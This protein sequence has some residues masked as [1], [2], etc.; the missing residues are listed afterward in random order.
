MYL[1]H[2][3]ENPVDCS[4]LL[5]HLAAMTT[6]KSAAVSFESCFVLLPVHWVRTVCRLLQLSHLTANAFQCCNA[7]QNVQPLTFQNSIGSCPMADP[8]LSIQHFR[9]N[10][11]TNI[12]VRHRIN[13]PHQLVSVQAFAGL[14][15]KHASK[16]ALVT[17]AEA[18]T[19]TTSVHLY[20]WRALS[21]ICLQTLACCW[22]FVYNTRRTKQSFSVVC[23]SIRMSSIACT[24]AKLC[25]PHIMLRYAFLFLCCNAVNGLT[26]LQQ[27][28][29]KAYLNCGSRCKVATVTAHN[30]LYIF[31]PVGISSLAA[32]SQYFIYGSNRSEML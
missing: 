4:R 25:S 3:V 24:A 1:D 2:V 23:N 12:A 11:W 20:R 5:N 19:T 28:N 27:R 18:H 17:D 8:Q 16:F 13:L 21:P 14:S 15:P 7:G 26:A 22:T 9:P 29:E 31:L 32:P 6:S 30:A 10:S